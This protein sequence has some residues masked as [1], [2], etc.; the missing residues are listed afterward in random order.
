MSQ[1]SDVNK[2]LD[3][4]LEKMES[5]DRKMDSVEEKMDVRLA[6]VEDQ[7][8]SLQKKSRKM[9]KR[10]NYVLNEVTKLK[11]SVN[12]LEQ[13]KLSNNIIIRGLKEIEGVSSE[14][15]STMLDDIF[16]ALDS[17]YKSLS[18]ARR[19][20]VQKN[21]N[22]RLVLV[23]VCNAETKLKIMKNLKDKNL[24]CSQF[25]HRG[26][27]WGSKDDK[28]FLNDHLTPIS[29]NLFFQARQLKKQNKVKYAWSKLGKIYIRK[30]DESRA[31]HIT[32]SEQL[33][34]LEKRFLSNTAES[35]TSDEES[36]EPDSATEDE[37][38]MDS[39]IPATSAA[40]QS[41]STKNKRARSKEVGKKSPRPKRVRKPM[42]Q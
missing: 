22:P 7:C 2:K 39:E 36:S 19:I 37:S 11:A 16:T 28:I 32:S 9:E 27:A 5:F 30:D 12:L 34:Q 42:K 20:G 21:N 13:E 38:A 41:S 4:L 24:N 10:Q 15:L 23:K 26:A 8:I 18:L 6:K 29:S 40:S 33:L 3:K 25:N 31:F 17:S 14:L 35:I 1:E